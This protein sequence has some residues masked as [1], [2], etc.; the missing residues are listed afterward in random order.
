MNNELASLI[1]A[2][3]PSAI[4]SDF[5]KY[6]KRNGVQVYLHKPTNRRLVATSALPGRRMPPEQVG[7]ALAMFY[8]GLSVAETS[9]KLTPIFDISPPSKATIYEWVVDYTRLAKNTL[10][11]QKVRTGDT[12]VADEMVVKIAGRKYWN[13]NVMDAKTRY[14]L[15]SHLSATRGTRDAIKV[16]RE[17]A[18]V[19]QRPPK[20]I[21]TDRLR[22]YIDGIERVFGA[23]SKHVQS[24]GLRAE[25]NNNLSERLQGTIRRRVKVMRGMQRRD[26][27]QLVMDGWNIDYNLFRPHEG[28]RGKTPAEA[29]KFDVPFTDW[30]SVARHDVRPFSQVRILRT[31]P[32][33]TREFRVRGGRP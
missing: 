1:Q 11:Q 5:I 4:P 33:R 17:A 12:W 13:W 15:A 10:E 30:E 28:L 24:Q 2:K 21:I 22:S 18:Q 26:T 29:A 3:M 31:K 23:D 14:L 7:A 27:A 20:V 9:R 32:I 16:F 8:S 6:G 25:V 19:A